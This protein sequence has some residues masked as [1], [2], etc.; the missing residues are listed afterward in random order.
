MLQIIVVL[1]VEPLREQVTCT[2]EQVF[3]GD[4]SVF[5]CIF[6]SLNSGQSPCLMFHHRD[7]IG[8]RQGVLF[9]IA[10]PGPLNVIKKL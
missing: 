3:F 8:K 5:G 4:L 10:L 1:K 7:G 9:L 2:L 6:H